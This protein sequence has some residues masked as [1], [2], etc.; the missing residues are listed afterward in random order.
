MLRSRDNTV[1]VLG[2]CMG[3]IIRFTRVPV[4]R[5]F[6]RP[7]L[8]KMWRIS[9]IKADLRNWVVNVAMTALVSG[10]VFIVA[11]IAAAIWKAIAAEPVP[12]T[13]FIAIAVVGI[14]LVASAIVMLQKK[15]PVV[16]KVYGPLTEQA[17]I[18]EVIDTIERRANE[19]ISK[20]EQGMNLVRI[21]VLAADQ[22]TKVPKI[23]LIEQELLTEC[24]DMERTL[25]LAEFH[26]IVTQAE[27]LN[28]Q[29]NDHLGA[30]V[31]QKAHE[32]IGTAHQILRLVVTIRAK[33]LNAKS[34]PMVSAENIGILDARRNIS[35]TSIDR[36]SQQAVFGAVDELKQLLVEGEQ[37]V[38]RYY[39]PQFRTPSNDEVEDYLSRT[40]R[41]AKQ[42][43]L[44]EE[45]VGA[46]QI[47]VLQE[48]WDQEEL[49]MKKAELQ[50]VGA[51]DFNSLGDGI[52]Q[53]VSFDRLYS[54]TKRLRELL[55]YIE[56]RDTGP[57]PP[58][59]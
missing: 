22:T 1:P 57:R 32:I 26:S 7:R 49:L 35:S 33:V 58:V 53:S 6:G 5:C 14:G 17:K 29:I 51:I 42:R 4:A 43:V 50:D 44:K 23:P 24:N 36:Y 46:K 13:V 52:M 55:T 41:A 21:P 9:D 2:R 45:N 37:M 27:E 3:E 20:T 39:L 56:G 28:H 8:N 48:S 34:G 15:A 47:A 16:T 25:A 40:L 59:P 18:C 11:P 10:V 19:I 31:E 54:R 30:P 38:G 12:W